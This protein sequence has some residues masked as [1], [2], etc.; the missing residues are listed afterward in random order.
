MPTVTP[1]AAADAT[2]RWLA[3][4][5]DAPSALEAIRAAELPGGVPYA[6]L[7]GEAGTVK[8]PRRHLVRERQLDRL[9]VTFVGYWRRGLSEEQSRDEATKDS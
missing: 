2:V 3:R 8:E 9:H 6:W 5:E 7:A 1:G 4:D